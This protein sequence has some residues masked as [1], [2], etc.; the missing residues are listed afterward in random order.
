MNTASHQQK[1]TS[2]ST[3]TSSSNT[4]AQRHSILP[5]LKPQDF[6]RAGRLVSNIAIALEALWANRVRSLLTT[7]GIFIGVAAVIA[8]L[9]MTQGVSASI[10]NTISSLG[11]NTITIA[12]GAGSS[13]R[14]F[15]PPTQ[16][17]G[18]TPSLTTD[19][20]KAVAKVADITAISPVISVSAQA[21]YGNQN[22]NTRI[23]GVSTDLQTI[24]N[25][26][27]EQGAWFSN[28]DYLGAH[29]VAVLGQT[30]YQQL[31][32]SSS[33]NPIGQHVRI[34]RQ[35]YRV[36]GVL[37]EKGSG[38]DDT[39]F[40]PFTTAQER[41]KTSVYI[42]QIIVQVDDASNID[43]VQSAIIPLLEQRHH[44][45][46]GNADDF[47]L[48][49]SNQLLQTAN[50]FTSLLT[51]LLVGI[52]AISLAVGGIGIMNIMI[53]SVTERTREIGI[54][55][56]IGAQRED[57]RNQF[58]IEALTLSLLGG[59]LGMV[60]GFLLGFA[61]TSAIGIPFVITVTALLM[62]FVISAAIGVIFGLYPAVRA[63]RLDPIDALRSL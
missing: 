24:Q 39:V 14:G 11:T 59:L 19:D 26:S 9:L 40:V 3:S 25:W 20:E 42:D 49:N 7:L 54:R 52:A 29:S 13:S 1:S 43:T 36:V 5:S 44:I 34:D 63:A 53:V 55:I 50:Q 51:Y 27:V 41:I 31:F 48:T 8:A 56:S 33:A 46:K 62:P 2:G 57:I 16:S 47:N 17:S 21:V 60:I 18:T 35:I 38:Q 4:S 61:I 32:S 23:Q 37:A 58:L 6:D 45:L 22:W 15:R 10:T 30:V 12:P 28:E